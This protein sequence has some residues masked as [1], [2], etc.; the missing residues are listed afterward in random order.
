MIKQMR[1]PQ[2]GLHVHKSINDKTTTTPQHVQELVNKLL[3]TNSNR[4]CKQETL[5]LILANMVSPSECLQLFLSTAWRDR[6]RTPILAEIFLQLTQETDIDFASLIDSCHNNLLKVLTVIGQ[7]NST[8]LS[9]V[10][11]MAN[12]YRMEDLDDDHRSGVEAYLV[13]IAK[14]FWPYF[15]PEKSRKVWND[16]ICDAICDVLMATGKTLEEKCPI[17]MER[18]FN[19]ITIMMFSSSWISDYTLLRFMELKE[20]RASNWSFA[21][22]ARMYYTMA[23]SKVSVHI[24]QH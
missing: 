6:N 14:A 21:S 10:T 2:V 5:K 9:L 3:M 11:L 1:R 12:I 20:M 23:Y 7:P 4:E 8:D 16:E 19:N 18:A 15:I 22:S 13:E 24:L 17:N